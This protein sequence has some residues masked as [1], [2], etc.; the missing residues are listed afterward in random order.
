MLQVAYAETTTLDP[1]AKNPSSSAS[2][3]FGITKGTWEDRKC[4]GDV[5]DAADNIACARKIYDKYGLKPWEASKSKWAN[6]K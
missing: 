6:L 4:T 2:G 1:L 3:L 5:F